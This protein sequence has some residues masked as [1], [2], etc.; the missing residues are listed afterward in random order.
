[1][2][3][4]IKRWFPLKAK[5][6]EDFVS[7]IKREGCA[8]IEGQ[9]I[10][11]PKGFGASTSI[12][13]IGHSRYFIE[14]IALTPTGRRVAYEEFCEERFGSEW[15]LADAQDRNKLAI[16]CLLTAEDRLKK[17]A[18]LLSPYKVQTFVK[19]PPGRLNE[20]FLERLHKDAETLGVTPL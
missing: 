8:V 12:G 13:R 10:K 19:G 5:S 16:R 1:M 6:L 3:N 7:I 20:G 9:A 15:G 18:N 17:L 4:F 14:L 11:E 2:F